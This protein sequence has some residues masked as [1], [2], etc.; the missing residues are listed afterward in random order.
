LILLSPRCVLLYNGPLLCAHRGLKCRPKCCWLILLSPRC[1]LK[2]ERP[3]FKSRC[4]NDEIVFG[5]N[6][7]RMWSDVLQEQATMVQ[8]PEAGMLAETWTT[9][10]VFFCAFYFSVILHC[11][12][13][14]MCV[15]F[16]KY[17]CYFIIYLLSNL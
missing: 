15:T 7:R 16:C 8:L 11:A 13:Y 17:L 4:N 12:L 10:F 1:I 2:L 9:D 3:K 6:C 5:S 14:F